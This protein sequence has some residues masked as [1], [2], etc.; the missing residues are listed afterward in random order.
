[1]PYSQNYMKQADDADE[2][3][4]HYPNA[5]GRFD[6][7][8]WLRWREVQKG[9]LNLDESIREDTTAVLL[10]EI[11]EI[12]RLRVP[13]MTIRI[14]SPGGG[15]YC[16][17]AIYDALE[18][19][20]KTPCMITSI[21]EG[22]AASAAA[23]VVLQAAQTRQAYKHT[24][25]LL[26]ETRRWAFFSVEKTSELEEEVQE[27]KALDDAVVEILAKRCSKA[28]EEVRSLLRRR[29]VW[30]SAK[31]ALDFNLIDVIL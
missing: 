8:R 12:Q 15:A 16:A 20:Q 3:E 23:M 31:E 27:M 19:L 29:E 10:K 6:Y 25:F 11:R 30:M 26:H 14:M 21:A 4:E 28:D 9:V 24:R 5:S 22:W 7:D 13:E 1:V 2:G 17:L 18:S